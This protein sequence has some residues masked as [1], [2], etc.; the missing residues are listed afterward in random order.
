M[1]SNTYGDKPP[2]LTLWIPENADAASR[3]AYDHIAAS[4]PVPVDKK[5]DTWWEAEG[6]TFV[7]QAD[8]GLSLM[9]CTGP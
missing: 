5:D 2:V 8:G 6:M 7:V 4:L 9:A 1:E 3:A